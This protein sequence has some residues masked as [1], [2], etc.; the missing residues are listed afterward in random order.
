M[1]VFRPESLNDSP[2]LIRALDHVLH[3]DD[4]LSAPPQKSVI[5]SEASQR[6]AESKDPEGASAH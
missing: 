1:T 2:T 5:L 3:G 4:A 6:E